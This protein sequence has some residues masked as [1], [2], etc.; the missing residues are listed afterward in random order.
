MST[1]QNKLFLLSNHAAFWLLLA[2]WLFGCTPVPVQ[3]EPPYSREL[4]EVLYDVNTWS[5][6]G[7]VAIISNDDSWQADIDW[8]HKPGFDEIN[9]S[10]PLGQG[11][12]V[13]HLEENFVSIARGSDDV[14]FSDRPEQFINEQLGLLVPV[15]SL[16]Y[17][18]LGLPK[19]ESAFVDV[20]G[21]FKQEGWQ[22]LYQ[23]MQSIENKSLPRKISVS[24][25]QAK[26]KLII[27][28]WTL[29]GNESE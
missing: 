17:W 2:L 26:L 18:V 15:K 24:N 7:R 1:N 13:I 11:K 27:D 14:N 6:S 12:T 4:S 29:N 8:A 21:G 28:Q 10:G 3:K 16:R 20:S 19:P 9:L 22:V 25:S 5:M 23:Q